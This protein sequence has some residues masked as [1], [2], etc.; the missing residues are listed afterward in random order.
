MVMP[1]QPM[2]EKVRDLVNKMDMKAGLVVPFCVTVETHGVVDLLDEKQVKPIVDMVMAGI[3]G[4]E[5][6]QEMLGL[7][8]AANKASAS[9]EADHAVAAAD[10][11][12]DSCAHLDEERNRCRAWKS[13]TIFSSPICLFFDARIAT[14]T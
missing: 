3:M 10:E 6:A 8:P 1:D 4:M 7:D 12:C 9:T 5:V 14:A 11:V 2:L 13:K